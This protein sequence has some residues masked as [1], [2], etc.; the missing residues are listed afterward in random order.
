MRIPG[1]RSSYPRIVL[2]AFACLMLGAAFGPPVAGAAADKFKDVVIRNTPEDPVPVVP[3]GTTQIAGTVEV[4]NLPATQAI[5][6]SVSLTA[7][8]TPWN[9][10]NHVQ[11]GETLNYQPVIFQGF[12]LSKLALTAMTFANEGNSAVPVEVTVML[13][14]DR[15][16]DCRTWATGNFAAGERFLVSAPAHDTVQLTWPTPLVYSGRRES[17]K[18]CVIAD[19]RAAT[20]GTIYISASGFLPS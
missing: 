19:P 12:G 5:E 14:D 7:P 9:T 11:V 20:S 16:E 3:Q 1:S 10:G 8:A 4:G 15:D 2:I 6:G 18:F 13:S 17:G